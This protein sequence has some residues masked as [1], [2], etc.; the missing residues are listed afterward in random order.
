MA[1]SKEINVFNLSFLDL[2][3]GALAAVIILFILVPKMSRQEA[4]AMETLE[5]LEVASSDLDSLMQ[6]AQNGVPAEL[7]AQIQER[8][9]AMRREMA[10]LRMEIEEMQRKL[11]ECD[12]VRAQL[13]ATQADL[14]DARQQAA[15][16]EAQVRELE[17]QL[18]EQP[19][20][21]GGRM[22]GIDAELGITCSW[23]QDADVDI[24]LR[25]TAT[26]E[27]CSYSKPATL[28]A[29]LQEDIRAATGDTKYELMYQEKIV[30]GTYD[31]WIH[32]YKETGADE[33]ATVNGKVV[34]YPTTPNEQAIP[35]GPITVVRGEVE[36]NAGGGKRV[37]TLKVTAERIE[38]TR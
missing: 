34:L 38:L 10:Q 25:N 24:W 8:M 9:E 19:T 37:G 16:A 35:F 30:P 29:R 26:D 22:F 36:P 3:S 12:A 32:R 14:T 18:A 17:R 27:W 23:P 15:E 21:G 6:L 4:E 13:E 11:A 33:S 31:L 2:L 7:Y 28:F 20:P 1:R 5:R